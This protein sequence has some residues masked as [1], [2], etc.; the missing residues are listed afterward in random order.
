MTMTWFKHRSISTKLGAAFA[1]VI[2]LGVALGGST[3]VRLGIVGDRV[4]AMAKQTLPG[5]AGATAL[6]EQA[7][8]IRRQV[9]IYLA[10]PS[11][12]D[13]QRAE[14]AIEAG[15]AAF[16]AALASYRATITQPGVQALLTQFQAQWTTYLQTQRELL[17]LAR[18]PG[19]LADATPARTI[20]RSQFDA[21][22]AT[23]GRIVEATTR[24]G[25]AA[26]TGVYRV[27][28]AIRWWVAIVL[29]ISAVLGSAIAFVITRLVAG[30]VR[31][32]ETT[33]SAMARGEL[34][35]GAI[36]H[37]VD[38]EIGALARSFGR[39]TAALSAVV[40]ELQLLIQASQRGQVGMRGDASRFEGVYGELVAG[41]N[42]LLD[43]LVS[44]LQFVAHNADALTASSEQLTA[45]SQ[46][47]GGSAAEAS[48][49]AQLVSSA[50]GDVSRST[51]SV[52]TSTEQMAASIKEIAKNASDS[53]RV[54]GQ[55]VKMAGT[56]NATV[57]KLGDSAI[58]IG[59]V[60]KVITAIAQQT[61]LLALNAT[62][63]AA[64]AGEAGKGFA[65]VA[66]EVKELAKETAKATEDIGR[67][68]E[69]IQTD[70]QDAIA[71]IGHIGAII[72]QIDDIS[73][74]I[75]SAVEQQSATTNEMGRNVAESARGTTEIANNIA[76]VAHTAQNTA[77]GA[78]QTMAAAT[79]LAQMA[80][81]LK[82][83][84]SKFSFERR[85]ATALSG[86]GA[87]ASRPF[88]AAGEGAL[89]HSSN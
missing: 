78:G 11:P 19:K 37:D 52:A 66:N 77:N 45:V 84:V 36:D 59:K 35:A 55:A 74:T 89:L 2:A 29:A 68:I 65:V 87:A 32:L 6:A 30:P 50:A 39:S 16:T 69:S 49:L 51:H 63:E 82:Q 17:V 83:L 13:K 56:T 31:Q 20:S 7:A 70:T 61:N 12:E 34:D 10:A 85:A 3:V 1:L 21:A 44:P 58:E 24:D 64:R 18:A 57:G 60:V 62:I 75:A 42:A 81:G 9:L 88:V 25:A 23:L 27:I 22:R 14:A 86:A 40:G 80:A 73:T 76:T 47:L 26:A 38:D 33:A 48:S 8:E 43:S 41:T 72:A 71:A 54:A 4:D 5:I 15:G 79:E 53:A 28:G 46:Q 67:S